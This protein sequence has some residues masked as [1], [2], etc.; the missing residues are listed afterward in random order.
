MVPLT[1]I[2]ISV[3]ITEVGLFP[4]HALPR[5]LAMGMTEML[6]AAVLGG[7]AVLE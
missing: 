7:V 3:E 5:P 1:T 6:D 2:Y 4:A